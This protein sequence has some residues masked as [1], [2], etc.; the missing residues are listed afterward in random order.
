MWIG[1]AEKNGF[2]DQSWRER[3][4]YGH[5]LPDTRCR[6]SLFVWDC[7]FDTNG[8]KVKV[9][10]VLEQFL[11]LSLWDVECIQLFKNRFFQFVNILW[12]NKFNTI[13]TSNQMSFQI[14]RLWEE[15]V[16]RSTPEGLEQCVDVV[17][18]AKVIVVAEKLDTFFILLKT[19]SAE[20]TNQFPIYKINVIKADIEFQQVFN[21]WNVI[22]MNTLEFR[23]VF[24]LTVFE[25]KFET[26]R[27]LFLQ[28]FGTMQM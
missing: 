24:F 28:F 4:W 25:E 2:R 12:V 17:G 15:R 10:K 23:N 18:V 1:V 19:S 21:F 16:R 8:L 27:S 14:P 13:T 22:Q 3:N 6:L 9:F 26:F 7:F 5:M 20:L 11:L